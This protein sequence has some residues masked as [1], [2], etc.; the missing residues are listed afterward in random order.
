MVGSCVPWCAREFAS[1]GIEFLPV[2]TNLEYGAR[3]G[4]GS[5]HALPG[6][7]HARSK[8]NALHSRKSMFDVVLDLRPD[9]PSY[10]GMVWH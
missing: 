3:K 1:H 8:A 7:Y 9:S 5:R 4:D 6:G 10:R 2:Q